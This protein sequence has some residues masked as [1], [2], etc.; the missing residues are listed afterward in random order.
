MNLLREKF[1][2][3]VCALAAER[4]ESERR[5]RL[6]RELWLTRLLMAWGSTKHRTLGRFLRSRAGRPFRRRRGLVLTLE[7]K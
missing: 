3:A 1:M 5:E 7:T 2:H 4:Y 6:G